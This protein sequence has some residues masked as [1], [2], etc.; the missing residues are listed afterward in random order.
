M[1]QPWKQ[2]LA[3]VSCSPAQIRIAQSRENYVLSFPWS[4]LFAKGEGPNCA[5]GHYSRNSELGGRKTK[6]IR[7]ESDSSK[8]AKKN[9]IVKC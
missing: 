6:K 2:Q 1:C 7:L 5:V 3:I 4:N 9:R 8:F